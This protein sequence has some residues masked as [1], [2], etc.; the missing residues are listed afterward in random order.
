M[1]YCTDISILLTPCSINACST[2]YI[3]CRHSPRVP[4]ADQTTTSAA[5][6]NNSNAQHRSSKTARDSHQNPITSEHNSAQPYKTNSQYAYGSQAPSA[7]HQVRTGGKHMH[8][9]AVQTDG[10]HVQTDSVQT[11]LLPPR[12]QQQVS[13]IV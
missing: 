8:S 6:H 1:A 3:V 10:P 5:N 9:D 11:D 13:A 2:L 7:N 4:H 12:L